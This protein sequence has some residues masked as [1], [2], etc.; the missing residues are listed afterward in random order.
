L[1]EQWKPVP[2]WDGYEVSDLGRV[3][4]LDRILPGGQFCAGTVLKQSPDSRGYMRVSLQRGRKSSTKR[5]HVLVMEAFA[6]P[7]PAGMHILHKD[8]DKSR[9]DINSLRYGTGS[10]NEREKKG[11]R[12]RDGRGRYRR[13]RKEIGR[14]KESPRG[15][16]P[17]SPASLESQQ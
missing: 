17:G 6:G 9:N 13:G 7:R 5:V 1:S 2:G 3:R 4:S 10:E 16:G 11:E 14:K 8:D 15:T 12:E